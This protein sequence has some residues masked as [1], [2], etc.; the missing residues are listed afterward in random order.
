MAGWIPIGCDNAFAV[1]T[2]L[3][4]LFTSCSTNRELTSVSR[5]L[6]S[7]A[8][9]GVNPVHIFGLSVALTLRLITCVSVRISRSGPI[10]CP[11]SQ[12][13][14]VARSPST[15]ASGSLKQGLCPPP[16]MDTTMP[17]KLEG[18]AH[19]VASRPAFLSPAPQAGLT[20]TSF[21]LATAD[22][23]LYRRGA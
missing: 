20:V 14:S 18:P 21:G 2:F 5:M 13:S 8:I 12:S 7:T 22:W 4:V 10:D 3:R 16:I 23:S 6:S 11:F 19:C 15:N 1:S 17:F 9:A